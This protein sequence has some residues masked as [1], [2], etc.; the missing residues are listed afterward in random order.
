VERKV[1]F[2]PYFPYTNLRTPYYTWK[3]TH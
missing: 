3:E 1:A 2:R